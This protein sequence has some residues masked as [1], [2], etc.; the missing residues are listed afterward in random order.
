MSIFDFLKRRKQ[1]PGDQLRDLLEDYELPSF[2][3]SVMKVLE[4]LRDPDAPLPEISR[5]IEAD[6]GM[7]VRVLKTVNSAAYGLPRKIGNIQHAI[8]LLGKM[9][10]EGIILP[11]AVKNA[12]PKTELYCLRQQDFWKI[13]TR[14]ACLA[15]A[16]AEVLHPTHQEEC[17]TAGLLQDMAIPVL[18]HVK[19]QKYCMTLEM[20]NEDR[21]A[22]LEKL[23]RETF[24]VDHQSVGALM[25]EKWQFP[26]YLLQ[27]ILHHHGDG[28]QGRV[29]EAVIAVSQIRYNHAV[30]EEGEQRQMT[31]ILRESLDIGSSVSSRILERAKNEA[32]EFYSIF[33]G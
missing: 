15:K 24:G 19:E 18:I 10:L 30:R 28:R 29:P 8:S 1:D 16:I 20:W 12:I 4:L 26:D 7:H 14:R 17:F 32:D 11:I 27:S 5:L 2:P 25:A 33:A 31:E 22:S 13:S 9:R 3:G 23:E 6:P 21:Q